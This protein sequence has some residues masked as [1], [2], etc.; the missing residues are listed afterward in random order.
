[1][2]FPERLDRLSRTIM[3]TMSSSTR[4]S[5]I[6]DANKNGKHIGYRTPTIR[7]A[8]SMM[9]FPINYQ[10]TGNNEGT[11]YKQIGNAV[12]VNLAKEVGYSLIKFLNQYYSLSNPK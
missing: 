5:I 3:A 7:E 4:E 11:K 8:S 9:G 10:F 6:Y 12:P 2:D 1:M